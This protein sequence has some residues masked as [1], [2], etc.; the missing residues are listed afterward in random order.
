MQPARSRKNDHTRG[1]YLIYQRGRARSRVS[2]YTENNITEIL[3]HAARKTREARAQST[4]PPPLYRPRRFR[5]CGRQQTRQRIRPL[6]F[7]HVKF[8]VRPPLC[9]RAGT[10]SANIIGTHSFR[11]HY[12]FTVFFRAA[13]RICESLNFSNRASY[14]YVYRFRLHFV[15][16]W[17]G[18]VLKNEKRLWRWHT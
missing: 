10:Q 6:I 8:A 9:T 18:R 2:E 14:I 15:F 11:F 17:C 1:R 13:S 16:F 3:F 7:P 5:A 4:P 12:L